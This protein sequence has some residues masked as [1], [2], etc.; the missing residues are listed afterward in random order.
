MLV[1][2]NVFLNYTILVQ[3]AGGG[4]KIEKRVCMCLSVCMS[5]NKL[6]Q[7]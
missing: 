2:R 3:V 7:I 4:A 5:A 6:A 1:S